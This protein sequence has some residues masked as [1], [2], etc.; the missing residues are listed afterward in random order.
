MSSSS[1]FLL[2]ACG[3]AVLAFWVVARFPTVGPQTLPSALAWVIA[4]FL[5]QLP[6]PLLVGSTARS[7]G[8]STALLLVVLPALAILFW[9]AGCL[10]RSVVSLIT[11]H[12]R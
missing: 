8:A 5:L 10:V 1:G 7:A 9:T 4:A 2:F 11:P 6:V 12:R 3:A